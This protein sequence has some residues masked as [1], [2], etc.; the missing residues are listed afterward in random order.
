M[1]TRLPNLAQSLTQRLRDAMT[2]V[3]WL[4]HLRTGSVTP[5]PSSTML[6]INQAS[7]TAQAPV[8][9]A[10][11]TLSKEE[12]IMSTNVTPIPAAAPVAKKSVFGFASLGHFW[13]SVVH[14]FKVGEAALIKSAPKVLEVVDTAAALAPLV[15]PEASVLSGT[16]DRAAHAILG[17]AIAVATTTDASVSANGANLTL[18]AATIASLKQLAADIKS[19]GTVAPAPVGLPVT[20][21]KA[22]A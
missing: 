17:D 4:S 13:A 15:A 22:A 3:S 10:V 1:S 16:V 9:R 19:A 6:G 20:S 7:N 14:D 8:E 2:T 11:E 12:P 18:D 21:A 5:S